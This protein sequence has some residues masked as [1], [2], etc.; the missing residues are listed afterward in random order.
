MLTLL[1]MPMTL[2]NHAVVTF[3]LNMIWTTRLTGAAFR[4]RKK[5]P[6]LRADDL[7][8]VAGTDPCLYHRGGIDIELHRRLAPAKDVALEVGRNVYD[9]GEPAGI[10]QRHDVPLGDGRRRLEVGREERMG[11]PARQLRMILSTMPTDALWTSCALLCAW[12][13]MA[14]ENV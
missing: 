7:L 9:K 13:M 10:H 8:G 5:V 14:I 6:D 11:D 12:L 4:P 1:M 3:G 2:V